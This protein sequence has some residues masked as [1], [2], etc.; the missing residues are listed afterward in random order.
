MRMGRLLCLGRKKDN[1][2]KNHR[3]IV[4]RQILD[5]I[6]HCFGVDESLVGDFQSTAVDK[7]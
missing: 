3:T 5:H 6:H 7:E 4:K 1:R 2:R